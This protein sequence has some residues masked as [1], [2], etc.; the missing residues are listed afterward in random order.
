MGAVGGHA[1]DHIGRARVEVLGDLALDLGRIA[2]S[3]Q[4][5]DEPIAAAG[6]E[7]GVVE[8]VLLPQRPVLG[9]RQVDANRLAC[10]LP[11]GV[12]VRLGND[13]L[14]DEEV[15]VIAQLGSGVAAWRMP[16]AEFEGNCAWLEIARLA[17][18][19]GKWIAQLA[20]EPEVVRWEWK[21]FRRAFVT[22]AAKVISGGRQLRVRIAEA[23]HQR[24]WELGEYAEAVAER[25]PV[26]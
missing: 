13:G 15:L 2:P 4:H 1:E 26:G 21:R 8:S 9:S 12:G 25:P 23:F 22:V 19:L 14:D 11:S 20:L 5:V 6:D 16:V 10:Q 3:D 24:G 18:N 7:V 17:W